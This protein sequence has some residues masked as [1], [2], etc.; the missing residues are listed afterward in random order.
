MLTVPCIILFRISM[1]FQNYCQNNPDALKMM[2]VPSGK[3]NRVY[4]LCAK[5][6]Y[7]IR[8]KIKSTSSIMC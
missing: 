2:Q 4:L 8:V 1:H 3:V 5:H 6:D 7:S